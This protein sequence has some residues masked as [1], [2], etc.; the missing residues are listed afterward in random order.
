[1]LQRLQFF[2]V[3][4]KQHNILSL[5]W[6]DFI[7]QSSL[8]CWCSCTCSKCEWKLD[9]ENKIAKLVRKIAIRYVFPP[10]IV[11]PRATAMQKSAEAVQEGEQSHLKIIESRLEMLSSRGPKLALAP[12]RSETPKCVQRLRST[13]ELKWPGKKLCC[14]CKCKTQL[15]RFF[16]A[17]VSIP[18]LLFYYYSVTERSEMGSAVAVQG[19]N[20]SVIIF[21][22]NFTFQFLFSI[23][24][25]SVQTFYQ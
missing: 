15:Y 23:V 17:L 22:Q 24:G 1:M 21:F 7:S 6:S 11:Q 12:I 9:L 19:L 10:K 14:F 8:K 13:D 16:T 20:T 25:S 3:G 5:M 2:T 4:H 18:Q